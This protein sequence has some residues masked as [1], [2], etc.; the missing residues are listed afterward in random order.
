MIFWYKNIKNWRKLQFDA[1]TQIQA[2]H[3]VEKIR[4]F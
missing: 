4:G 1:D 3:K 2:F